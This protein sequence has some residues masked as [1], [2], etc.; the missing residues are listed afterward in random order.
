MFAV[1]YALM[2]SNAPDDTRPVRLSER[3]HRELKLLAEARGVTMRELADEAIAALSRTLT[4]PRSAIP[5]LLKTREEL[6]EQGQNDVADLISTL[7]AGIR[8]V[9]KGPYSWADAQLILD[10]ELS[11]G[12]DRVRRGAVAQE[13][14]AEP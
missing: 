1:L 8:A 7:I 14:G 2:T 11:R 5:T 9:D 12:V 6:R 10:E 4:G 13:K 3:R